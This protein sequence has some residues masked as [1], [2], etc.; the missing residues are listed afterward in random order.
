MSD[1]ITQTE[2]EETKTL[3]ENVFMSKGKLYA[4]LNNNGKV[5]LKEI[6]ED[7]FK[8]VMYTKTEHRTNFRDPLTKSCLVHEVLTK[9]D[10]NKLVYAKPKGMFGNSNIPQ[11]FTSV[12][13]GSQTGSNPSRFYIDIE[14]AVVIPVFIDEKY[15]ND[16]YAVH[17]AHVKDY[18]GYSFMSF[19][20][21]S[22]LDPGIP[23]H[24]VV[25][26][27]RGDPKE[28]T[29]IKELKAFYSN[30]WKPNGP[31][32]AK[33]QISSIQIHYQENSDDEGEYVLLV[34]QQLTNAEQEKLT[35]D[36]NVKIIYCRTEEILLRRYLAYQKHK[37]PAIISGWNS[38]GYD[39]PYITLRI[40]RV[41]DGCSKIVTTREG[42]QTLCK[43][44]HVASLS[45]VGDVTGRAFTSN[46]GNEELNFNWKGRML[47]DYMDLY[48]QNFH[49][50]ESYSLSYISQVEL[51]DDKVSHDFASDF[52][53]FHEDYFYDFCEYGL[54]DVALLS[55]LEDKLNMI[56]LNLF[57][58]ESCSVNLDDTL[59]TTKKVI[60]LMF[61][62]YEDKGFILPA[63]NLFEEISRDFP[64]QAIH[65]K[66]F[67]ELTKSQQ[68]CL[69]QGASYNL[70]EDGSPLGGQSFI[71]GLV[72]A[73][74]RHGKNVY[75]LD[76]ASL[77]PSNIRK[78][79]I[80]LD[81]IIPVKDLPQEL[82]DI[83]IKA[84]IYYPK[85]V[86][87]KEQEQFDAMFVNRCFDRTNGANGLELSELGLELS[88][89]LRKYNVSMSPNGIFFSNENQS[90][91]SQWIEDFQSKRKVLKGKM[92]DALKEIS[93]T[94]NPSVELLARA[95]MFNVHQNGVKLLLNSAYGAMSLGISVFAGNVEMFSTPVTST[96]RVANML[97]SQEQSR[98]IDK[99]RGTEPIE[100]K[101]NEIAFYDNC[102]Q[103]DTDS[104]YMSTVDLFKST[105]EVVNFVQDTAL[106]EAE[107]TL[108]L[109]ATLLNSKDP[110]ALAEDAEIVAEDFVSV[111]PKRY[112][113]NK[114][115]D[116]G[117]YL[118]EPKLCSTG[119]SLI[120]KQVPFALRDALGQGMKH[121]VQGNMK[122]VKEESDKVLK[123]LETKTPDELCQFVNF[124]DDSF[125][126]RDNGKYQKVN[127]KGKLQSATANTRAAC[128]HNDIVNKLGLKY[129]ELQTGTKVKVIR[130]KTPNKINSDIFA[131]LDSAILDELELEIDYRTILEKN[132]T[133]AIAGVTDRIEGWS[134]ALND[135][136]SCGFDGF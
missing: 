64:E 12:F 54:K 44:P 3:Y 49:K 93:E 72:R 85:G 77:Y 26:G 36:K 69:K 41:L 119:M 33:A 97:V 61:K 5:V 66:V 105:T 87:P 21:I 130:V 82:I 2:T 34:R 63:Q 50:S 57:V 104:C 120:S 56:A 84:A 4:R 129:A 126:L 35:K 101:Y 40:A 23:W 29:D 76:F 71:G 134:V 13:F 51:Q 15:R 116:E 75:S 58:A 38:A 133:K 114:T 80:G 107:K 136:D 79:N 118:K 42:L 14:T 65:S 86:I 131:Y 22:K 10:F 52:A 117:I 55:K 124:N 81:T 92:K 127:D 62:Y 128:I 46:F 32:A 16:L 115:W 8:P 53:E 132:Y 30:D 20:Q 25:P 48:K 121:L 43:L 109:L 94:T 98:L 83:R 102:F 37:D 28:T 73:T 27:P 68:D 122:K 88:E 24:S 70:D 59:G 31:R 9:K 113:Y 89:T 78:I 67:D 45:P 100:M 123:L 99:L 11:Q 6:S 106:P 103:I 91:Y 74:A 90:V 60:S 108:E 47:L 95:K 1:T 112:F 110:K 7:H 19:N 96:G 125:T 18:V 135:L 111:A 39:I 17:E